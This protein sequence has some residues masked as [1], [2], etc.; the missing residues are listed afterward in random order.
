MNVKGL[1]FR[2]QFFNQSL[3]FDKVMKK[4]FPGGKYITMNTDLLNLPKT[5]R[6]C[7]RWAELTKT[8][9][10]KYQWIEEWILDDWSF[11]EKAIKVMYPIQ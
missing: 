8:K 10:A 9:M 2:F 1:R 3:L 4:Q 6:E 5:W 11:P 7:G